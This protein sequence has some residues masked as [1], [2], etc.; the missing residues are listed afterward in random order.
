GEFAPAGRLLSSPPPEEGV[1]AAE[2]TG[3]PG[4]ACTA[5][6]EAGAQANGPPPPP[7]GI[8]CRCG[9]ARGERR[10]LRLVPAEG[11]QLFELV[12]GKNDAL[13][14]RQARGRF[15]QRLTAEQAVKLDARMLPRPE[16]GG[17]PGLPSRQ[18][19]PRP[20]GAQ[21]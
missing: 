12:D 10:A 6:V 2:D 21:A 18:P 11:E 9:K 5:A 15:R 7:L 4:M 17:P 14:V 19:A 8:E 13:S 1:V 3:E 16:P 20:G